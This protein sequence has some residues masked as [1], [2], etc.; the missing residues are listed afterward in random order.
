MLY[1]WGGT[2]VYRRIYG[3][4]SRLTALLASRRKTK[5]PTVQPT[6]PPQMKI[7]RTV[8]GTITVIPL[9]ETKT[10]CV[11]LKLMLDLSYIGRKF[12]YFEK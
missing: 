12:S 5:F 10:K 4:K 8:T 9:K 11:T 6:I 2:Y 3:Q 7:P 1:I